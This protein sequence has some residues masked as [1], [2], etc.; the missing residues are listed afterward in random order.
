MDTSCAL[1]ADINIY[2]QLIP[3]ANAPFVD[4][5]DVVPANPESNDTK[6]SATP[7]QPRQI[8]EMEIPADVIDLIGGGGRTRTYD[9]RIMRPSL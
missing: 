2:R 6:P 9:L 4:R 5:L 1:Y 7:A 8:A 3:G